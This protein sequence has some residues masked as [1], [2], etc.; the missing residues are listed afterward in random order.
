[1]KAKGFDLG[2]KVSGQ[3]H[4]PSADPRTSKGLMR[5]AVIAKGKHKA[6]PL[7]KTLV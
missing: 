4:R 1:M 6:A 5:G 3:D 2:D 7:Q